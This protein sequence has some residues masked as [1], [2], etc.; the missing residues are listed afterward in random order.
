MRRRKA[1]TPTGV[2]PPSCPPRSPHSGARAPAALRV[3]I[4]AAATA[5]VARI[6]ATAQTGASPGP[7]MGGGQTVGARLSPPQWAAASQAARSLPQCGARPPARAQGAARRIPGRVAARAPARRRAVRVTGLPHTRTRVGCTVRAV[8][9]RAMD[10]R[11]RLGARIPARTRR[12][13]TR[14]GGAPRRTRPESVRSTQA[15]TASTRTLGTSRLLPRDVRR[16]V[17]GARNL[18]P[19]HRR[20]R[21]ALAHQRERF[22]SVRRH[23]APVDRE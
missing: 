13:A 2:P 15:T 10:V 4:V 20:E 18:D 19:R 11:K 6:A 3:T 16:A 9:P 17:A 23:L 21:H 5:A 8:H 14:R 1:P 7:A 22:P 12:V